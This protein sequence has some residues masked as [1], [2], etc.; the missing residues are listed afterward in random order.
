MLKSVFKIFFIACGII[1]GGCDKKTTPQSDQ[2]QGR[3]P[4]PVIVTK[5]VKR[6]FPIC[7]SSVGR[8]RAYNAVDV[9]S[10][11]SGEIIS[12]D[13]D[14][15]ALVEE[16]QALFH[17]SDRRYKA[18]LKAA[19]AD[20]DRHRAQLAIDQVQLERSK[21]LMDKDYISKQEFETYSTR[22]AQDQA[23]IISAEAAIERAKID[24]E[25]CCI[26]APFA[27]MLGKRVVDRGA[28][29][30]AMER[31]ISIRQMMPLGVDFFIS[32]NDFPALRRQFEANERQLGLE[33]SL[34]ADRAVRTKGV[35][36]FLDNKVDAE[37]GI[38]HLRGEFPNETYRFWP[39]CTVRVNVELEV[40]KDVVI[41]P[42]ESM[43]VDNAGR[44]YLYQVRADEASA[45]KHRA[46]QIYPEIGYRNQEFTTIKKGIS[47]GE[48]IILRG[49]MLLGNGSDVIPVLDGVPEGIPAGA[50]GGVPGEQASQRQKQ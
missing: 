13:F 9:V 6:D 21:S 18:N 17:L 30:N 24:L 2:P 46:A 41:V 12:V 5:A 40:L 1:L 45:T 35:L 36:K 7:L 34:I 38:I 3:P 27:G 23:N 20:L 43:K 28:V 31:L 14:E 15:G 33:I 48:T 44:P 25:H 11:I 39:G 26:K 4:V 49:S 42:A 8:C 47:N 19:E 16:G 50:P 37:S 29:I 32:E 10:Q 22:V